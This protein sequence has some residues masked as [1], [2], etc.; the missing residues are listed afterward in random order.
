MKDHSAVFLLPSAYPCTN[1]H[2]LY[3]VQVWDAEHSFTSPQRI[4]HFVLLGYFRIQKS[5]YMCV[6]S[7]M[8]SVLKGCKIR[9]LSSKGKRSTSLKQKQWWVQTYKTRLE[10]KQ[11]NAFQGGKGVLISHSHVEVMVTVNNSQAQALIILLYMPDHIDFRPAQ[12]DYI[13][14]PFLSYTTALL[15][16]HL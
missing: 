1:T 5:E 6:W 9:T 12:Y 13:T 11:K 3:F 16:M 7:I 2:A 10:N 4:K 8:H 15:V 14:S